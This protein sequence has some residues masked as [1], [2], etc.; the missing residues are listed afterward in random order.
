MILILGHYP[1]ADNEKDGM[2]QRIVVIDKFLDS[3]K[4]VYVTN[5]HMNGKEN[6]WQRIRFFL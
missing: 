3:H 2:L 1:N 6:F 4:R 5:V